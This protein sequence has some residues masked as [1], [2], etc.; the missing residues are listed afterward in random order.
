LLDGEL[1]DIEEALD[2]RRD[3]RL[4]VVGRVVRERLGEEDAGVIFTGISVE[5]GLASTIASALVLED[6]QADQK[7]ASQHDAVTGLARIS[8]RKRITIVARLPHPR[9]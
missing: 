8:V 7:S 4:E 2:V 3:E 9:G 1:G 5:N 6:G